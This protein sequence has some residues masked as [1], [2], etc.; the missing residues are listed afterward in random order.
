[1]RNLQ[2]RPRTSTTPKRSSLHAI[3]P[4]KFTSEVVTWYHRSWIGRMSVLD[5]NER[6]AYLENPLYEKQEFGDFTPF[7]ITIT[8]ITIVGFTLFALNIVFGCCSRYSKYWNDRHTG[9]CIVSFRTSLDL[10]LSL[11]ALEVA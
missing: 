11:F 9:N 1:M 3:Y 4:S 7:Y 8:I 5:I 10:F 2:Q 6:R